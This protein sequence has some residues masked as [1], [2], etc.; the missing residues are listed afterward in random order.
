MRC[1]WLISAVVILLCVGGVAAQYNEESWTVPTVKYGETPLPDIFPVSFEIDASYSGVMFQW[2]SVIF[3]FTNVEIPTLKRT[4][5]VMCF[6]LSG[7]VCP[8]QVR[9]PFA[10]LLSGQE[11]SEG[12]E[13][14]PFGIYDISVSVRFAPTGVETFVALHTGVDLRVPVVEHQLGNQ[15]MNIT[16][17]RSSQFDYG[18]MLDRCNNCEY[19]A[20]TNREMLV[21]MRNETHA[22]ATQFRTTWST[23]LVRFRKDGLN[24]VGYSAPSLI[25]PG[26]YNVSVYF[27]STLDAGA[28]KSVTA[29]NVA[30][31]YDVLDSLMSPIVGLL[32]PNTSFGGA[33]AELPFNLRIPGGAL[34]NSI[35]VR[36]RMEDGLV[37]SRRV[38]SPSLHVLKTRSLSLAE[39]WSVGLLPGGPTTVPKVPFGRMTVEIGYTTPFGE[40]TRPREILGVQH[41]PTA[42]RATYDRNSTSAIAFLA[43]DAFELD[44]T[45]VTDT[46]VILVSFS[47]VVVRSAVNSSHVLAQYDFSTVFADP[48]VSV[49]LPH[50]IVVD[51]LAM[52]HNEVLLWNE[53]SADLQ[54]AVNP[55]TSNPVNL[56]DRLQVT[57]PAATNV[58]V[59]R[60]GEAICVVADAGVD[61]FLAGPLGSEIVWDARPS[62]YSRHTWTLLSQPHPTT[63]WISPGPPFIASF[64]K[65]KEVAVFEG[66]PLLYVTLDPDESSTDR[67]TC[68]VNVTASSVDPLKCIM[69]TRYEFKS[70]IA[71]SGNRILV[72]RYNIHPA[73]Y[74][75][76]SFDLGLQTPPVHVAGYSGV[77]ESFITDVWTPR[78]V[79]FAVHP[80]TMTRYIAAHTGETLEDLA[81]TP[82]L[83]RLDRGGAQ[84]SSVTRIHPMNG[85]MIMLE[86]EYFKDTEDGNGQ[87][88]ERFASYVTKIT[89]YSLAPT[90]LAPLALAPQANAVGFASAL[91]VS[92]ALFDEP[93]SNSVYL[94]L[95]EVSG[96]SSVSV[97][98][99][100]S[101]V[102]SESMSALLAR[103][104]P[105]GALLLESVEDSSLRVQEVDV[106][107]LTIAAPINIE[108]V[109]I[110]F[111]ANRTVRATIGSNVTLLVSPECGGR[112][113]LAGSLCFCQHPYEGVSCAS[114]QC[115]GACSG[116]GS[117]DAATGAPC[118]V[119]D[120]GWGGANCTVP[121]CTPSCN[122]FSQC[123][124][125]NVCTCLPTRIG[126]NCETVSC[127]VNNTCPLN[128]ACASSGFC[129]CVPGYTGASCNTPV[130]TVACSSGATCSA[131]NTCTC[132]PG[133]TGPLCTLPCGGSCGEYG[134]CNTVTN[135][136]ACSAGW[137]GTRC[138]VPVCAGGCG[139]L[140]VGACVA[141]GEC[142]CMPPAHGPNC[143]L[144]SCVNGCGSMGVCNEAQGTCVCAP[145]W[146]GPRCETAVCACGANGACANSTAPT[147]C[148]CFSTESAA[149]FGPFCNMTR[150]T[151]SEAHCGSGECGTTLNGMVPCEGG[152]AWYN[153]SWFAHLMWSLGLAVAV[154]A[155]ALITFFVVKWRSGQGYT[156]MGRTKDQVQEWQE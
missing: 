73:R 120:A 144:R 55:I 27:Y 24:G 115:D 99:P 68:A 104:S 98:M 128:A 87:V 129:A 75:I 29:N 96:N 5:V 150:A 114:I 67:H 141:P 118:G 7:G 155:A 125:P 19:T 105:S 38:E 97:Q 50:I 116:H 18:L 80:T 142:S 43:T 41:W 135:Q 71:N 110:S 79:D 34:A 145:G 127:A 39:P 108:L 89:T 10:G 40:T 137:A 72:G 1:L 113:V 11:Y 63:P 16:A 136:C 36:L 109:Y 152:T 35:Y 3:E 138:T 103:L 70:R 149:S 147:V 100:N 56:L 4:L 139:G 81:D 86:T 8:I 106:A 51:R 60:V 2:D 122:A 140:G 76:E 92:Y 151:C 49:V 6:S 146:V 47:R 65:I 134:V 12:I 124:A 22:F 91:Q 26:I 112:G 74:V 77:Y 69:R 148:S 131:P 59:V 15:I 85:R 95:S 107:F 42:P 156:K 102:H 90:E 117:C 33:N 23:G 53:A 88:V 119:C 111:F 121:Q 45:V 154:V 21:V 83:Y 62:L 44:N 57:M 126:D 64:P 130:C 153:R 133:F 30:C 9:V 58:R 20:N 13:P 93:A 25:P 78:T 28:V 31:G 94:R 143:A 52:H 101:P 54:A 17:H 48:V 14:M 37:L 66:V 61:C 82:I 32:M 132:L 46:V 84:Q 123:T